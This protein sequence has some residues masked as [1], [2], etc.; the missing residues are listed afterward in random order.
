MMTMIEDWA[1][2]NVSF[3]PWYPPFQDSAPGGDIE[4]T[5]SV[6]GDFYGEE[7]EVGGGGALVNEGESQSKSKVILIQI[8]H[9]SL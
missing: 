6:N 1:D 9:M 4:S 8:K 5:F 7:G 3:T 2:L